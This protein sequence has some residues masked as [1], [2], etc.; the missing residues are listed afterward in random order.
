MASDVWIV[1]ALD[2]E[3]G[4]RIGMGLALEMGLEMGAGGDMGTLMAMVAE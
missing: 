4:V 2:M 3:T 1:M